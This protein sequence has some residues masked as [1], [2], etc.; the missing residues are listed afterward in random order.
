MKDASP[1]F[2]CSFIPSL[3]GTGVPSDR[4]EP[5]ETAL[6]PTMLN[7]KGLNAGMQPQM[8]PMLISSTLLSG[9]EEFVGNKNSRMIGTLTSRLISCRH[10]MLNQKHGGFEAQNRCE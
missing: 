6:L 7:K 10:A 8:R 1:L 4:H 5:G 2:F 3:L 9:I